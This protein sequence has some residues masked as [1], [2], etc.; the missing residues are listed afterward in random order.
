MTSSSLLSFLA[1]PIRHLGE[2][3]GA[4]YVDEKIGEF[5]AEDE[6]TLVL[7][8]AQAA[9]V[10][11]NALPVPGRAA[12]QGAPGDADRHLPRGRGG[13]RRP[14]GGASVIQPGGGADH[15]GPQAARP[16][17]G[18]PVGGPES[19]G[20][21]RAGSVSGGVSGGPGAGHG[22]DSAGRGDGPERPRR[23]LGHRSGS[24]PRRCARRK[25]TRWKPW[26][27]PSRT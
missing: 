16:P 20:D 14:N 6:E 13:R 21:R 8:A 17:P 27:S 12:G 25:A 18:R 7:F 5:T 9:L 1:A 24:T 10:I 23:P 4:L 19:P 22:Q 2:N 11:A 26:W 3:M 15:G